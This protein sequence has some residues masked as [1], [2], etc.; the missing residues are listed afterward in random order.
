MDL[1]ETVDR[2]HE[3][4]DDFARGDPAPVKE[5]Y[6]RRDDVI[7]AN[8]FVGPPARGWDS[9]SPALDYASARFRDGRVTHIE[10]VAEYVGQDLAV[11]MELE[12]WTVKFSGAQ[13]PKSFD[14]RVTT[15][16]RR[17]DGGW[18]LVHRHADPIATPN[19]EGPFR[20]A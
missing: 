10:P 6:S 16:F 11:L 4:L 7:I 13:D 9:V 12:S 19:D 17:E 5:L 20:T 2:Y 18:K 1:R 3:V 15:T 14:L 8:P